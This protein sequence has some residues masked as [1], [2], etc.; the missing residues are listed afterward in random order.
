MSKRGARK[1]ERAST[2]EHKQAGVGVMQT[3]TILRGR[4]RRDQGQMNEG[5]IKNE[6][7]NEGKGEDRQMDRWRITGTAMAGG[8]AIA[9]AGV[10]AA[11]AAAA[12]APPPSPPPFYF[13][14][15]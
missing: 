5:E 3:G 13:I 2:S 14:I 8:A 15:T 9:V 4:L 6:W 1:W 11:V 12:A 7:T 10:M